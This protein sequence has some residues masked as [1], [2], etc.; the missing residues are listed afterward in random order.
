MSA[1]KDFIVSRVD[2]AE[3]RAVENTNGT[4]DIVLRLDGTFSNRTA[5]DPDA[6]EVMRERLLRAL[7]AD[8]V[9]EAAIARGRLLQH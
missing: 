1:V 9:S 6:V 8:G 2:W 4:V 7:R 3:I 5:D